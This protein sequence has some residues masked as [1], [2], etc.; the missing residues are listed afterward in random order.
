MTLASVGLGIAGSAGNFVQQS[1]YS[2]AMRQNAASSYMAD[3]HQLNDRQMQE[4]AASA[5][6]GQQMQREDFAAQSTAQTAA[7][8]AGVGG[9]STQGLLNDLASQQAMREST[10]SANLDMTLNQLQEQKMGAGVQMQSRINSAPPPSMAGLLIQVGGDAVGGYDQYQSRTNP[11]W[12]GIYPM[13]YR[14]GGYGIRP[15]G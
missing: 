10:N 1:A 3:T 2:S 9:L 15:N 7:G 11:N 5:Q 8:E 12:G 4:Q 13:G 6:R 14:T